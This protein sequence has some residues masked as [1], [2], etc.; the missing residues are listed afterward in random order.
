MADPITVALATAVVT[1]MAST[2]SE[3]AGEAVTEGLK[4][5]RRAVFKRFRAD[6]A[7]QDALDEALLDTDDPAAVEAVAGHLERLAARDPEIGALVRELGAQVE[8]GQ[9]GT[10]NV[11]NQIHGDVGD[12]AKVVQG[13]DFH[14]DIHL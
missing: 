3:H 9:E 4:R 1:G 6:E 13:R 7:A 11:T 14:G 8:V 10:G 2:I 12:R 5:L